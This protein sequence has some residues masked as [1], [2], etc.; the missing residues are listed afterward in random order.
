MG[1]GFLADRSALV[2]KLAVLVLEVARIWQSVVVEDGPSSRFEA[3]DDDVEDA[4]GMMRR[5]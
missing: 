2:Q 5:V 4:A 3:E 1:L